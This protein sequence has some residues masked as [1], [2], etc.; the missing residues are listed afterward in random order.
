MNEALAII[1]FVLALF[2]LVALPAA[3]V[4]LHFIVQDLT[5]IAYNPECR[6]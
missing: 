3:C 2:L 4:D 6:P 1:K 5:K